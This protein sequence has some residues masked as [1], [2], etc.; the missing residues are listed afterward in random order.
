MSVKAKKHL[1]QHFLTSKPIAAKIAAT[2]SS[3]NPGLVLEIGPGKGI[4]TEQLIDR[5]GSRLYVIDVDAESVAYL[6]K[7]FS[8]LGNRI[9]EGDFLKLDLNDFG[10][11]NMAVIGNYPYNISSQIL[12]KILDHIDIVNEV[13]GMFQ[14][15]VAKRIASGPGNKQYGLLSVLLQTWYDIE[16]RFSVEP[17]VFDPPPKVRS[18]VISLVRNSRSEL[19]VDRNF[20]TRVVKTAFGQRRKTLRNS[21]KPILNE[22]GITIDPD[23]L[24]KRPEQL[25]AEEFIALAVQLAGARQGSR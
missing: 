5:F 24:S 19:G 18:G 21:L 2:L 11:S 7:H 1:G 3:D 22:T 4:L 15:E 25:A 8:I 13:S 16:Y 20:Y 6:K 17:D 10:G 14:Y 9:I 23:V 12:F